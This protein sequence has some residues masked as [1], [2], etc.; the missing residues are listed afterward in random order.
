MRKKPKRPLARNTRK[1]R[2]GGAAGNSSGSIGMG[3]PTEMGQMIKK[4]GSAAGDAADPASIPLFICIFKLI[5]SP[6][7]PTSPTFRRLFPA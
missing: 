6:F 2:K 5:S 7:E 4:V 3:R 1:R